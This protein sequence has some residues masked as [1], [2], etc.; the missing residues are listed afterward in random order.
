MIGSGCL[1]CYFRFIENEALSFLPEGIQMVI[2]R[3]HRDL[4]ARGMPVVAVDDLAAFEL[5]VCRHHCPPE[6]VE[7][8]EVDHERLGLGHGQAISG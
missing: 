8:I 2:R 5:A 6:V 1:N 4:R 7:R 3:M